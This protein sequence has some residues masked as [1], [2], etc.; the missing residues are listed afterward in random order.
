MFPDYEKRKKTC[1]PL[2]TLEKSKFHEFLHLFHLPSLF[3]QCTISPY[4]KK[5]NRWSRVD[6]P[7]YLGKEKLFLHL[8]TFWFVCFPWFGGLRRRTSACTS[9]H[10]QHLVIS[11]LPFSIRHLIDDK[12]E[13]LLSLHSR[14]HCHTD[15]LNREAVWARGEGKENNSRFFRRSSGAAFSPKELRKLLI[16]C[17]VR[18]TAMVV[19][20]K[21]SPTRPSLKLV[22]SQ[23]NFQPSATTDCCCR[24]VYNFFFSF[25]TQTKTQNFTLTISI[26]HRNSDSH[27]HILFSLRLSMELTISRCASRHKK[28]FEW[29]FCS[30]FLSL[31]N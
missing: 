28:H 5:A 21:T 24:K 2:W 13:S 31:I 7:S 20:S 25:F 30:Y 6:D 26:A 9:L 12:S 22:M 8:F 3:V 17:F 18:L 10:W 29:N 16:I 19:G 23:S 14:M 1:W 15:S 27:F 11:R 4:N